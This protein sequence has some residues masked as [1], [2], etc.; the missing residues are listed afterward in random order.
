MCCERDD[1]LYG[2][3]RSVESGV[4]RTGD[5]ITMKQTVNHGLVDHHTLA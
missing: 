5:I 2:D 1:R 3:I 4:M